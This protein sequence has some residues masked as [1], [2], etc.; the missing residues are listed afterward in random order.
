MPNGKNFLCVNNLMNKYDNND[1]YLLLLIFVIFQFSERI[2]CE[3][4]FWIFWP[5]HFICFVCKFVQPLCAFCMSHLS[6]SAR[7]RMVYLVGVWVSYILFA[8]LHLFD[9]KSSCIF[10]TIAVITHIRVIW[11]SQQ[12]TQIIFQSCHI[13]R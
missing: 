7:I 3:F 2:F 13:F 1:T 6:F 10:F 8:L 5:K 9:F 4:C 12:F 11:S